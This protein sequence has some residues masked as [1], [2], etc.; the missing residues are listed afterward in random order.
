MSSPPCCP[1][2]LAEHKR[3][4][5]T[6]AAESAEKLKA[7][8]KALKA[9]QEEAALELAAA[10]KALSDERQAHQR[11]A[12]TYSGCCSRGVSLGIDRGLEMAHDQ[13]GSRLW[14]CLFMV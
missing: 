12:G 5:K 3:Q 1:P 14:M 4:E 8:Q 6:R 13:A 11:T 7:A 10:Q 2:Q 9:A